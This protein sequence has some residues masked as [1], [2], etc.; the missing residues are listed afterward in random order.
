MSIHLQTLPFRA[1]LLLILGSLLA[2]CGSD[3]GFD[4]SVNAV[5]VD[6]L[7]YSQTAVITIGGRNLRSSIVTDTG[8]GCTN[9]GTGP[10]APPSSWC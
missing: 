9:P 5:R 7:Q 4:P 2:A 3:N 6:R 10:A 1:C 8:G